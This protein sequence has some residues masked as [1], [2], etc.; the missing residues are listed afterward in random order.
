[1]SSRTPGWNHC[2]KGLKT[3]CS[4]SMNIRDYV[5][6][7]I[8][9]CIATIFCRTCIHLFFICSCCL[10]A[11]SHLHTLCT[12]ILMKNLERC[13][14]SAAKYFI[15]LRSLFRKNRVGLWDHVVCVCVCLCIPISLLGNDSVK[16][17]LSLLGNGTVETT[18]VTNTHATIEEIWTCRFQCGPGRIK[19]SR[20]LALPRTY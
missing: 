17:L 7:D 2:S 19:E 8:T 20:R 11:L 12:V 6:Y 4:S 1:M 15:S 16:I 9:F 10:T 5:E 3:K 14:K 18:A 13:W